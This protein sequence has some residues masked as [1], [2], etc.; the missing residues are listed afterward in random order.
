MAQI[1][2]VEQTVT[3]ITRIPYDDNHYPGMSL[4]DALRCERELDLSDKLNILAEG[5]ADVPIDSPLIRFSDSV[6]VEE[7][8]E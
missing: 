8:S 1:L 6:T 3:L 7:V 5:L 2:R 4:E